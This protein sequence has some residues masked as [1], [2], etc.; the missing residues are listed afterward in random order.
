MRTLRLETHAGKASKPKFSQASCLHI[1]PYSAVK[2]IIETGVLRPELTSNMRA[3]CMCL[4]TFCAETSDT[5]A[6]VRGVKL[7]HFVMVPSWF[8]KVAAR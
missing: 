2:S 7:L 8:V 5:S 4:E 1:T 3:A 6:V